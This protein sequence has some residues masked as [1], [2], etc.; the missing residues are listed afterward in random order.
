M[1]YYIS[2]F[3]SSWQIANL[4]KI[5]LSSAFSSV[6]LTKIFFF[7]FFFLRF[8]YFERVR[9]RMSGEGQSKR[10][11]ERQ[12]ERGREEGR[13]VGWENLRQALHRTVKAEPDA[14]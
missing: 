6:A 2:K 3:G 1:R 7:S 14:A 5:R 8:I 10:G 4:W 9:A 13:E 11:K 12:R